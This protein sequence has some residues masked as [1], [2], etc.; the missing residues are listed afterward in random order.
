MNLKYKYKFKYKYNEAHNEMNLKPGYVIKQHV[1]MPKSVV[2]K[3]P[4]SKVSQES[5]I[6]K[7]DRH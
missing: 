4:V 6:V 2:K 1:L 5:S 7:S 3:A